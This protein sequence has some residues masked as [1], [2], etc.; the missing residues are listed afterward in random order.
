MFT[1][2]IVKSKYTNVPLVFIASSS[3]VA[4]NKIH[5]FNGSQALYKKILLS[6]LGTVSIKWGFSLPSSSEKKIW[7]GAFDSLIH[8]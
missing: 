3:Y 7:S 4:N 5:S 8:F 6:D 1:A 2:P